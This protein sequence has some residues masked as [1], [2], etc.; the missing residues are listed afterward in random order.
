MRRDW[1]ELSMLPVLEM[2]TAT[3]TEETRRPYHI[4]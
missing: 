4:D 3:D 2:S 1:L